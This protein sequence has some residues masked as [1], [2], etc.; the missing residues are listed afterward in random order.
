[1][2]KPIIRQEELS[3]FFEREERTIQKHIDELS[4]LFAERADLAQ[5]VLDLMPACLAEFKSEKFY[6]PN[7]AAK[8]LQLL[9]DNR[10]NPYHPTDDKFRPDDMRD[11]GFK[12]RND[13]YRKMKLLQRAWRGLIEVSIDNQDMGRLEVSYRWHTTKQK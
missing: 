1:M 5:R 3:G 8:F 4:T 11:Y 12:S 10:N 6:T 7:D 2:G 9:Y 13:A